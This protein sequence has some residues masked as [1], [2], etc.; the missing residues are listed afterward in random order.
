MFWKI[1]IKPQLNIK[2]DSIEFE[3]EDEKI[4][5]LYEILDDI[6]ISND[7]KISAKQQRTI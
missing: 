4:K 6:L 1:E 5:S 7:I 3:I 2:Q